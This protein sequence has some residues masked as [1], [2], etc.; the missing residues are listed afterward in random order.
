MS[1]KKHIYIK[2]N[3]ALD[4]A[5][6]S[7]AWM[8][9]FRISNLPAEDVRPVRHGRWIDIGDGKHFKCSECKYKDD[10]N[11]HPYCS[12]CGATMDLKEGEENETI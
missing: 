12:N 8:V 10:Y 4:C 9:V 3:D 7:E 6:L 11:N 5:E 2:K 1:K